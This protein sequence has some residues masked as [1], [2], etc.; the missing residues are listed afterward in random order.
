M[1]TAPG[2]VRGHHAEQ[3]DVVGVE[4]LDRCPH[5][6]LL[7]P[8][9]DDAHHDHLR[10]GSGGGLDERVQPLGH[11]DG[12]RVEQAQRP[13]PRAGARQAGE[14]LEVHRG[15]DALHLAGGLGEG[16]EG[17]LQAPGGDGDRG[18][19]A[20]APALERLGR[21]DGPPIAQR[22]ELHGAGGPAVGDVDHERRALGS[23]VEHAGGG[24]FIRDGGP[25]HDHRRGRAGN[26]RRDR[27]RRARRGRRGRAR[28]AARRLGSHG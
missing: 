26:R 18:R 8:T 7:C 16:G 22:A 2:P 10:P 23:G 11:A 14:A 19:V 1:R 9:T 21:G 3:L 24:G 13:R 12:A 15:P 5:L 6:R 20:V 25:L 17:A 28:F 27:P 4:A